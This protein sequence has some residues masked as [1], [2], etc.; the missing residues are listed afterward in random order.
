MQLNS[1]VILTHQVSYDY[2][3]T[4]SKEGQIPVR[5]RGAIKQQS[6][7]RWQESSARTKATETN[8][9]LQPQN[10]VLSPQHVLDTPAH[11][12]NKIQNK[13]TFPEGDRGL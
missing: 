12:K 2:R 6:L 9:T 1:P 4:G 13:C 5:E 8:L 3:I 11:P 10:P 7:N